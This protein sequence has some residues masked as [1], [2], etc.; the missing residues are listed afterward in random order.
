MT[1]IVE[2]VAD[3]RAM[4]AAVHAEAVPTLRRAAKQLAPVVK[5]ETPGR[6]SRLRKQLAPKVVQTREGAVLSLGRPGG[7]VGNLSVEGLLAILTEG[8]LPKILPRKKKA[9]LTPWG[10]RAKVQGQKANPFLSHIRDQGNRILMVEQ[11]NG[12]E[13]A[14]RAAERVP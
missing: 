12:A 5:R 13:R 7:R 4:S 9:L 14:A 11:V 3:V 2:K 1:V 10:P 8:T 6:R